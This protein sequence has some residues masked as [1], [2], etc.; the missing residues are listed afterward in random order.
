MN[1]TAQCIDPASSKLLEQIFFRS[2]SAASNCVVRKMHIMRVNLFTSMGLI[3]HKSSVFSLW[4]PLLL[5]GHKLQTTKITSV[6][7][8]FLPQSNQINFQPS[9]FATKNKRLKLNFKFQ[10]WECKKNE[11]KRITEFPSSFKCF[12]FY[13]KVYSLCVFVCAENAINCN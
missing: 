12:D 7:A 13:A 10:L 6:A 9:S 3:K 11:R 1:S 4:F 5:F 8:F 2:C